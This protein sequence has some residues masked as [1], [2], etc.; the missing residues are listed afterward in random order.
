MQLRQ[1][2]AA[3]KAGQLDEATRLL[4]KDELSSYLPAKD[5]TLAV[6]SALVER[7]Q[8]HAQLGDTLAG[9]RD[10]ETALTLS[11][12]TA[13]LTELR[14]QLIEQAHA[15]AERYLVAEDATAALACLE[16]LRRRDCDTPATRLLEQVAK[17]MLAA[18]RLMRLGDFAAAEAELAA[19][20]KL[21]PDLRSLENR[22]NQCRVQ[23][24]ESRALWTRL[25]QAVAGGDW[26]AAN[27]ACER[28]LTIAPENRA[29]R[30]THERLAGVAAPVSSQAP[31]P[32]SRAPSSQP[33]LAMSEPGANRR[34]IAWVDAVGGYLICLGE[35]VILGQPAAGGG[36][37]VPI[38]A[39]LSR[40]HAAIRRDGEAYTLVP[41][42][43]TKLDG[44]VLE[45][46]AP[47]V[48]GNEIELGDGVR[49]RFRRP[50]P[51]SATAVLDFVSQHRTKPKVDAV[52]L[53]AQTCVFSPRQA[54][55]VRCRNWTDDLILYREGKNLGCRTNSTVII[56][57][58]RYEHRGPLGPGSRIQGAEFAITLEELAPN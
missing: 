1:A 15:E 56:D 43:S 38:L 37:D 32:A 10:L 29:A 58:Q 50:H 51:L 40:R 9:W 35:Q 17:R 23:L 57:D 19:A 47:L 5:V 31:R 13:A 14:R 26:S 21:R 46:P 24:G 36:A 54:C 42:Q 28:L 33:P 27:L 20:C 6:A 3:W 39:D 34:L 41:L 22:L 44:R 12:E 7:G 8:K 25:N 16:R 55:H 48:D 18:G 4:A 11:G 45:K 53:M 30:Q 2:E 49:L 52:V